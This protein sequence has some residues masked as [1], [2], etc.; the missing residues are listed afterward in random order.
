[1]VLFIASSP[2]TPAQ[3]LH[4]HTSLP[5]GPAP[6]GAPPASD[7]CEAVLST[8]LSFWMACSSNLHGYLFVK[9]IY[10][11]GIRS[12]KN[13]LFPNPLSNADTTPDANR[14]CLIGCSDF[15]FQ[16]E[17]KQYYYVIILLL[18]FVPTL[19]CQ[20]CAF[21]VFISYLV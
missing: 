5:P 1:M 9:N 8:F 7:L 15:L 2:A 20:H 12:V 14:Y 6:A 4:R 18:L 19:E 3:V 10:Y 11:V 13:K 21:N 16:N 17:M